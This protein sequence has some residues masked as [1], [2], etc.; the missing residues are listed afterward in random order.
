[1][2]I[3]LFNSFQDDAGKK[4][5]VFYYSGALSQNVIATM[6]DCLKQRLDNNDAKG[7]VT[8]KLFSS[9]IEMIQNALHYSPLLPDSSFEKIGAV[10]VGKVDD[11]FYIICGNLV[12]KKY[13]NRISEKIEVVNSMSRDEIKLA[14]RTQL[15]NDNH[16]DDEVSKGAGLGLLTLARDSISPIEFSFKDVPGYENEYSELHLKTIF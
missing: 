10:A 4:G 13:V 3:D 8:K 2:E 11:H 7:N 12:D 15:R 9:F 14:Y 1:V 6:G 16:S 5:I